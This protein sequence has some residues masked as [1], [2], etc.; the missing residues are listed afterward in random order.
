M[1]IA[2]RR[3]DDRRTDFVRWK[4]GA[5]QDLDENPL[6][7]LLRAYLATVRREKLLPTRQDKVRSKS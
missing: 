1:K 7:R 4:F 3:T 2:P 6:S 5:S